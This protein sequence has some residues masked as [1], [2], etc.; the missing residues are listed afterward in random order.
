MLTAATVDGADV[1]RSTNGGMATVLVAGG[2]LFAT[3]IAAVV[4]VE[5]L[6]GACSSTAAGATAMI[7]VDVAGV[8]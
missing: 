6:L 4:D 5:T 1:V 2:T 7:V 8:I 3:A